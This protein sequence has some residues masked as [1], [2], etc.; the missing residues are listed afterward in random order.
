MLAALECTSC[1]AHPGEWIAAVPSA[2]YD[3]CPAQ[4]TCGRSEHATS[5]PSLAP[6]SSSRRRRFVASRVHVG[7]F[8]R[9]TTTSC[10]TTS[11]I[12]FWSFTS[13]RL[14]EGS[15]SDRIGQTRSLG[16]CRTACFG[17]ARIAGPTT[18]CG[19]TTIPTS[20]RR[21][22]LRPDSPGA[23]LRGRGAETARF[24]RLGRRYA[25]TPTA[26]DRSSVEKGFLR[27]RSNSSGLRALVPCRHGLSGG[28]R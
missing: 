19:S 24:R 5:T 8:R 1:G 15:T 12:S 7:P 26:R 13:F 16:A 22:T 20:T 11:R 3:C 17:S 10:L 6:G 25:I 14:T 27:M 21:G 2:T 4:G 28:A 23:P 9:K 18:P